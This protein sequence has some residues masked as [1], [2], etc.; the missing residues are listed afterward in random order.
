MLSGG[1]GSGLHGSA[2]HSCVG[3]FWRVEP[4]PVLTVWG[5]VLG[6]L[7]VLGSSGVQAYY[8]GTDLPIKQGET[9]ILGGLGVSKCHVGITTTD[10]EF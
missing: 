10:S 1:S 7:W 8:V 5:L 2:L 3:V 4:S 6:G 9:M